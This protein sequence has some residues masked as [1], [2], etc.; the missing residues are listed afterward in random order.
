MRAK[1]LKRSS[2]ENLSEREAEL[3]KELVKLRAQVAMGTQLKSPGQIREIR[4]NIA[5]IQTELNEQERNAKG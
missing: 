2:R 4:K 3:R 1:E 5:R